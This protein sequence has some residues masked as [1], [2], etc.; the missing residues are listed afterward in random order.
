MN[1]S[2]LARE[3]RRLVREI[4]D[5]PIRLQMQLT[6]LI[7]ENF[8]VRTFDD[9]ERLPM[10]EFLSRFQRHHC[11]G[12]VPNFYC[13]PVKVIS[14]T[15]VGTMIII[16]PTQKESADLEAQA[17]DATADLLSETTSHKL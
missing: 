10:H 4:K 6:E 3:A 7:K 9:G 11:G 14:D 17:S 1:G 12:L 16:E 8:P 5:D 2:E 13:R 15:P